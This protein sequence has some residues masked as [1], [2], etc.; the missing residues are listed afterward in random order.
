[1]ISIMNNVNEVFNFMKGISIAT[2]V[3]G[4]IEL[5]TAITKADW[6]SSDKIKQGILIMIGGGLLWAFF[7]FKLWTLV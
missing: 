1:M 2:I 4:F 7:K 5:V 3:F 6:D